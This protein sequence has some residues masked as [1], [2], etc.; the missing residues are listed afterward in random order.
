MTGI[1]SLACIV[2]PVCLAGWWTWRSDAVA[3]RDVLLAGCGAVAAIVGAGA[4]I[5]SAEATDAAADYLGLFATF[6]SAFAAMGGLVLVLRMA[7]GERP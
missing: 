1:F 2:L 6:L 7:G 5:A 4:L 3:R